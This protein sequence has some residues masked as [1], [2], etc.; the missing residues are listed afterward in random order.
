MEK[1]SKSV[2]PIIII[3]DYIFIILLAIVVG[4]GFYEF[5]HT[6]YLQAIL[7][8]A[9]FMTLLGSLFIILIGLELLKTM[10]FTERGSMNFYIVAILDIVMIA[11]ARK[12]VLLS[13][14]D[15][16]DI[17]EY[18]AIGFILLV[19][20]LI[21]K[22]MPEPFSL[23]LK[24]TVHLYAVIKDEVG[25]LNKITDVLKNLNINILEAKVT[26]VGDGKSSLNATLILKK[27]DLNEDELE[28]KL[29]GLDV[30]IKAKV[31]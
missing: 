26:P 17:Y 6:L 1:F 2:K 14:K 22:Y 5:V 15:M 12:L 21:I 30:M 28:E 31:R 11:L 8:K 9:D 4:V 24:K 19:I 10:L 27:S 20:L 13:P 29:E 23:T 25:A 3:L 16:I 18:F 7:G